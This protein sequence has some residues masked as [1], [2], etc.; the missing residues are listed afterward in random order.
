MPQAADPESKRNPAPHTQ[1]HHEQ[2][3]RQG[4]HVVLLVCLA[5]GTRSQQLS[6][7]L[8]FIRMLETANF[9]PG[10]H[11]TDLNG[12]DSSGVRAVHLE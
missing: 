7:G 6:R 3:P 1:E 10:L 11:R 9:R 8:P 12:L 4:V 5:Q 2:K